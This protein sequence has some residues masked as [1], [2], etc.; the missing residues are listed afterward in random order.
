MHGESRGYHCSLG[1]MAQRWGHGTWC[2]GSEQ[3]GWTLVPGTRRCPAGTLSLARGC[4]RDRTLLPCPAAVC[5]CP[6]PH[7]CRLPVGCP[8]PRDGPWLCP[9]PGAV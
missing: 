3:G 9:L 6:H 8:V 5:P 2:S 1:V 4:L 7:P